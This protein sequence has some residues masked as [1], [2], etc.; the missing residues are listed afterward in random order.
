MTDTDLRVCYVV[1]AVLLT[2]FMFPL[3]WRLVRGP[4]VL[5]RIVAANVIGSKTTILVVVIG[6]IFQ[7]LSMFVDIAVTYALLNFL[8]SI[9]AARYFRSKGL[10][11]GQ[12][13]AMNAPATDGKREAPFS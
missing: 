1:T 12:S 5:D 8:V 10:K 4:T 11:P 9:A 13:V 2:L 6:A 7:R 3:S